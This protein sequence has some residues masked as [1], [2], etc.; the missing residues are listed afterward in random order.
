MV[1]FGLFLLLSAL[2]NFAKFQIL[3]NFQAFSSLK[4]LR[5]NKVDFT[6]LGAHYDKLFTQRRLQSWFTMD[7]RWLAVWH[8]M[9]DKSAIP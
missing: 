2:R 4:I 5:K 9:S 6:T 1:W 8:Y 7:G 3:Q